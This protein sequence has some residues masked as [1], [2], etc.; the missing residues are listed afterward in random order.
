MI[1][2][3]GLPRAFSV[4][5]DLAAQASRP[6]FDIPRRRKDCKLIITELVRGQIPPTTN[7]RL[8]RLSW[9]TRAFD[10]MDVSRGQIPWH[11]LHNMSIMIG[12][13]VW[14]LTS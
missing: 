11:R 7:N 10:G 6:L 2:D 5:V 9:R 13:G 8:Q 12:G 1:S 14:Y 3:H 4:I